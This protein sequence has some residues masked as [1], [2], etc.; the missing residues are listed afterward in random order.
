MFHFILEYGYICVSNIQVFSIT[1]QM[2][3]ADNL[4]N[5]SGQVY[6]Y[7]GTTHKSGYHRIS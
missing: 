3:Y 4:T 2:Y 1:R 5:V 6:Q 7:S